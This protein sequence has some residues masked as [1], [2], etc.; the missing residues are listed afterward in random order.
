MPKF[1][2]FEIS[3]FTDELTLYCNLF[4][5]AGKLIVDKQLSINKIGHGEYN[6]YQYYANEKQC[7]DNS[8]I[9]LFIK[10]LN[11]IIFIA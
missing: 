9:L 5:I 7:L 6:Y 11:M 2:I 4:N 8:V 10:E 1:R 3:P